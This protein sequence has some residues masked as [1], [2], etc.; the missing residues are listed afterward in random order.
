MAIDNTQF[1]IAVHVLT[2]VAK[3]GQ[4]S[5]IKL[6]ESVNANPIF[7][8]RIVGILVK[9]GLL[10]SFRGRNG[11]NQLACDAQ[12][13]SLLDVYRAVNAPVLFSIHQYPKVA[14]CVISSN[15]QE[16]LSVILSKAQQDFEKQLS[17]ITVQQILD[18]VVLRDQL[19][20][21]DK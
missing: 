1:S 14:S 20:N 6:A 10:L 16:S 13:I 2:G 21:Q 12:E 3:Y 5:S 9:N 8:K 7:I 19:L 15:I 18:D 17:Y 4:V 11:G